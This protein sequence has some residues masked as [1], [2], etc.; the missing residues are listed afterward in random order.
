MTKKVKPKPRNQRD[1][2][3][4]QIRTIS[5]KDLELA[6]QWVSVGDLKPWKDNPRKN[7]KAVAKVSAS[8]RR[9]GFSSP[10]V[11]RKEDGQ[12]IAGHTRLKAAKKLGMLKV[13]VRYL[14]ITA[15][16]AKLLALADNKIGEE[17]DWDTELLAIVMD[18]FEATD[19]AEAGFDDLPEVDEVRD[20][21]Q[22]V[23]LDQSYRVMIECKDESH[24]A[25]VLEM[26][27]QQSLDCSALMV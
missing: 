15:Q 16:E 26:C 20:A 27:K 12:V 4:D 7:D 23:E 6:A 2:S 19:L 11:A 10:I 18:E 14:D 8:M 3:T 25:E 21:S 17:A 9:F 24:Q 13:P 1:S 5:A 22:E